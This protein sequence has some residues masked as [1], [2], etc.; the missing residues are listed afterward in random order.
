MFLVRV[1]WI[2]PS[3]LLPTG[4][5]KVSKYLL[6]G[7]V[8]EG[9]DCGCLNPQYGGR[10]IVIDGVTHYPWIDDNLIYAFLDEFK[11]DI[12]I[13]YFST[14]VPPY[15][16]IGR[17]CEKKNIKCIYYCTVEYSSLSPIYFEALL[18]CNY[19]IT[20]SNYGK[21]V[22]CRNLPEDKVMVVPHGVDYSIYKP[23]NP[24]P[25]FEG[26]QDKFVYGM[27]ARNNIRKEFPTL[28]K[29]YSMLPKEVK[30]NSILYLHT[31]R[32]EYNLATRG[33][34]I[35]YL[36]IHFDIQG[37]VL[38]PSEKANRFYGYDEREMA[39]TY[40]AM[41]V[42]CLITS[43]EGFGLPVIES[44]A[45]GVPNILS[46]NTC[47]PEVGGEGALYAEC[48]EDE[49]YTTESFTLATTKSKS[50]M[51]C[52]MTLYY[53]EN[54]RKKL[55][56]K[57][58]ENAKRYSWRRAINQLIV[59]IE[60]AMKTEKRFG[61][62][63]MRASKPILAEG[64]SEEKAEFIPDGAGLCL[65]LG[66]GLTTPYR[67]IIERKG[68][69][70]I[71]LDIRKSRKITVLG[72]ARYLPFKNN[73]FKLVWASELLEHIPTDEQHKVLN[74]CLRVSEKAAFTFP[75][76][77][78]FTFWLDPSHNKIDWKSIMKLPNLK[79]DD[80]GKTIKLLFMKK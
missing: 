50:V 55:S 61:M 43:G 11:P 28:M 25:K 5:G 26:Y 65:D 74:E 27:V 48:W 16:M 73:A 68:Y 71:G 58:I 38:M 66:C 59:A 21:K 13:A 45:C 24:K 23:M 79:I 6:D 41:Y 34:D 12:V 53:D 17:I 7:L 39:L 54:L 60:E 31:S 67:S 44:Q 47:L 40:N 14:W 78:T 19:A 42:H 15:N 64:Y 10:P 30:D 63:I 29:A 1:G 35:P 56:E 2:S 49:L 75:N 77:N 76:E 36:A 33:W 46:K 52:M 72:D 8:R 9:F 32:E 22:L 18:G 62:E 3:P 4:I 20:P 69:E 70:Y 37:K 80:D 51:E 57:A